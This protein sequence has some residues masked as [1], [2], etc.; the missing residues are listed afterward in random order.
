MDVIP[1][2]K[3]QLKASEGALDSEVLHNVISYS[4]TPE[5]LKEYVE[6]VEL[7]NVVT[8]T[9]MIFNDKTFE[10]DSCILRYDGW[11]LFWHEKDGELSL[12]D[13]EA[14]L[15]S[16]IASFDDATDSELLNSGWIFHDEDDYLEGL[17][18]LLVEFSNKQR[19][20]ESKQ[21]TN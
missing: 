13:W 19:A 17:E 14:D 20:L 11:W 4:I 18:P 10:T 7:N 12:W 5:K 6:S 16:V 1:V 15:A 9:V 8:N 2:P 3:G 21:I